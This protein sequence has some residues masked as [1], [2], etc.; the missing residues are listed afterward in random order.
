MDSPDTGIRLH[1]PQIME[2]T[3]HKAQTSEAGLSD[4]QKE[5]ACGTPL[6]VTVN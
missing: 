4:S 5:A 2:I 6:Q 3:G 1:L